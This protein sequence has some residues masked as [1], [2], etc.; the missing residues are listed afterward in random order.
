[1]ENTADIQVN[2]PETNKKKSLLANS[3]QYGLYTAAA[4]VL[5]SLLL[6]VIDV[7][8][9]GW[10]NYLSFLILI[11]GIVVGTIAFRDKFSGGFLSYGRCLASGVL[12]S[13]VVGLVMALYSF[14]FFNYFDPG[15][16][17]GMMEA[18]EQ[19]MMNRGMT[20][21]QI[22]QALAFSGKLMSP[23]FLGI[24][25]FLSMAL[26]GTIISLITSA[27]L[28]KEDNSFDGAFRES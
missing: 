9:T 3:L 7:K 26:I 24:S 20:D 8:Q 10:I 11:A 2:E 6:Y 14:L 25:S 1:M 5:F 28:K 21:E 13:I 4:Y 19:E 17:A 27:F 16:L 22:D 23:A 15:A 12:I 18:S